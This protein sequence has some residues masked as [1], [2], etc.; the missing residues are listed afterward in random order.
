MSKPCEVCGATSGETSCIKDGTVRGDCPYWSQ[1]DD[2][3]H[4]RTTHEHEFV[5]VT[6]SSTNEPI[7]LQCVD[8]GKSW[9]VHLLPADHIITM[10][11]TAVCEICGKLFYGHVSGRLCDNPL[12]GGRLHFLEH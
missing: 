5:I 3:E 2:M 9:S 10:K 8:C 12:C 6:G 11:V 4:E 1:T 7:G